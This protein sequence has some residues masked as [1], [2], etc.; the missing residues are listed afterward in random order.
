[1][2]SVFSSAA[3]YTQGMNATQILGQE[4]TN[5]GIEGPALIVAGRSAL[6]QLADTWKQTLAEVGCSYS[7]HSFGGSVRWKK[8]CVSG[9]RLRPYLQGSLSAPEEEKLWMRHGQPPP[10]SAGPL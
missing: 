4:I 7:I 3:R 9:M 8:Y 1:M 2:L 10:N 5:L 6:A